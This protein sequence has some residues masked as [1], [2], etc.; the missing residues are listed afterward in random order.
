MRRVCILLI[1]V[2]VAHAG[3]LEEDFIFGSYGRVGFSFDQEG[4][5]GRPS[6]IVHYGPRLMGGD[7][8]E[9]DLGYWAYRSK[10]AQ[11][12]TLITTA[13]AGDFFHYDGQWDAS[14]AVRQ[15]YLEAEKLYGTGAFVWLG[16]RMYRG[17]DIYLLDVWPMDEL[18][19]LGL[20]AGY[21]WAKRDVTLH[22]GVTRL[23]DKFQLQRLTVP[24]PNTFG[25]EVI[26]LDRQRSVTS[27][28]LEQR[29]G[30]DGGALGVKLKLYGELHV[31]P[32]GERVLS[33]TYEEAWPLPDDTG[34]ML[35]AQLGLWNFA[36]NG[37]LNV[38]LRYA[39]GLAAYDELSVPKSFNQ[40]RRA[41]DNSELRA[42][43]SGNWESKTFGVLFGGYLRVFEDGDGQ[44]EDYDDTQD[45]AAA[46]RPQLFLG[47]FTPA[48]EASVQYSRPNG[49]H[50]LTLKQEAAS[51]YQLAFIPALTFA[52]EPG[53][54]SR[55][56]LRLIYAI[57]L[58]NDA[59]LDRYPAVGDFRHEE[60]TVHFIG[61]QAEWWFGRGGGY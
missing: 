17:D 30:G 8:L 2:G 34:Y 31:L 11:V 55:P 37:H 29:W 20:A 45:F 19:T 49:L 47:M 28:K 27:L 5:S 54:Y 36:R 57:S 1:L 56:Q 58:L 44:D 13:Y 61:A 50:P 38:W 53:S 48:V 41:V 23:E 46:I 14:I 43:F 35:G 33:D 52:D 9:V 24:D 59:A 16:S 40:D 25:Q 6:Q 18:N 32:K 42:A 7:Y 22:S 60:P 21:R 51:V 12:K 4:R 26:Y 15:A 10:Q 3:S 39:S